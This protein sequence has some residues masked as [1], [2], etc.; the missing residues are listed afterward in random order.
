[1]TSRLEV[2]SGVP[3]ADAWK[4]H[5]EENYEAY[6]IENKTIKHVQQIIDHRHGFL[7]MYVPN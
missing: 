7:A 2:S 1:M 5:R 3:T 4:F 6:R